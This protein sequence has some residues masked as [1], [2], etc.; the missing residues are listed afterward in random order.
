MLHGGPLFW[1]CVASSVLGASAIA[2]IAWVAGL[3][4]TAYLLTSLGSSALVALLLWAYLDRLIA[5]FLAAA[6][7]KRHALPLMWTRT[8]SALAALRDRIVLTWRSMIAASSI[9]PLLSA[10]PRLGG[11]RH[12]TPGCLPH[13]WAASESPSLA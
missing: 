4:D 7:G 9:T 13:R 10:N 8:R 12:T 1:G 5:Q 11:A 6:L 2:I 3:V